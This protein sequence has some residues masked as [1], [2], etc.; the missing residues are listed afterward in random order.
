M[1]TLTRRGL[2]LVLSLLAALTLLPTAVG[3]GAGS[4]NV[5]ATLSGSG[6]DVAIQG[7]AGSHCVLQLGAG[8]TARSIPGVTLGKS[9][10][11]RVHWPI[12]AG[13]QTGS[14]ELAATCTKKHHQLAGVA[15]VAIPASAVPEKHSVMA[16]VLNVLLDALLGGS[17]LLFVILLI[18]MVVREPSP[19]ERLMRSLAMVGGAIIA[20]G[21]QSAGVSFASYTVDSL[22]G[23]RPAGGAFTALSVVVPGGMATLFSWYF[24]RVMQRSAAMG[25]RLMSFLGML[26][27]I[28]FAVIFAQATNTQGVFLGEAAIPN[29]SFVAGLIGGV[30]IFMPT[31][32]HKRDR[33]TRFAGLAS[34]L[35]RGRGDGKAALAPAVEA[36][37]SAQTASNPF[38]ED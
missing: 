12:S 6:L 27:V 19:S 14:Q 7:R 31:A 8:P 36:P 13:T 17:L 15:Q 37:V 32:D 33:G 21:A 2:R 16:A 10:K 30:V 34:L 22:T 23:A 38:L 3:H 9:G 4:V 20:L 25:L 28:A 29:A 24:V 18:D 5:S 35:Q 26:T 1:F 11:G